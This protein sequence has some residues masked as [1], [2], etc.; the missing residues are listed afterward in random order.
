MDFKGTNVNVWIG[1]VWIRSDGK[2]KDHL[3][4]VMSHGVSNLSPLEMAEFQFERNIK[5]VAVGT[6]CKQTVCLDT[7][8]GLYI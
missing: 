1:F 5:E 3:N 2:R 4:T 8:S 6:R 7:A